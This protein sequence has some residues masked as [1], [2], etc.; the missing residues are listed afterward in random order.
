MPNLR[1]HH[2]ICLHFFQGKGYDENFIKNLKELLD[3]IKQEGVRI[4]KGADEVCKSCPHLKENRCEYKQESDKKI[5]EQDEIALELL[6]FKEGDLLKWEDIK[7]KL[8]ETFSQ[9][10]KKFCS[11]CDWLKVCESNPY[12][13]S[14]KSELIKEDVSH[15]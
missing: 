13:Q 4:I 12:F 6:D 3:K 8:P 15:Q 7:Q 9:W 10:Y 2:L 14:L 1:G 5:R 11:D